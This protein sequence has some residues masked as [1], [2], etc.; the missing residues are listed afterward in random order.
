[1]DIKILV[2]T[3]KKYRMPDD[4]M[5]I[6][7]QSGCNI[8]YD[9]GYMGDD[10]GDNI[11]YKNPAYNE[12]CPIYWAWKNLKADY[13]GIVHY[14]RHLSLKRRGKDIFDNILS[15]EEATM[16]CREND[17]I[18]P[19]KRKYYFE[20]LYKHYAKCQNNLIEMHTQDLETLRFAIHQIQPDYSQAFETIMNSHSA[21]MFHIFV[22]KKEK[23]DQFCD[24][25]FSIMFEV[26]RIRHE[27]R[28]DKTRYV[29]ALSEF[30]LDIWI[31]KN[32]YQFKEIGLVELEGQ[33]IFKRMLL[34]LKRKFIN[35]K[36]RL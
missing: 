31:L 5:Y 16:L 2:V 24:W 3:H 17:I 11:S 9:L 4:S 12:L 7:I 19:P 18:L 36:V 32:N 1:M 27:K 29:G 33:N 6:A 14:R 20:S 25:M 10:T 34:V 8:W 35:A 13:I 15:K 30:L 21:H 23:Y 22:M 28:E 26:E